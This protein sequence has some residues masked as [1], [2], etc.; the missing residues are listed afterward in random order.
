MPGLLDSMLK[1]DNAAPQEDPLAPK[2][3][4]FPAKAKRL[5]FLYMTGGV[6]H[7]D[8][9]DP[10]PTA[11]GRDGDGPD[12][13]MGCIFG[14]QK[15]PKTGIDVSNI[16][17]QIRGVM[18]HATLIRSMRSAH[19][20]HT[21]ATLGFHTCAAQFSRPSW[22]SW[23]SY[24]LGTMNRDLPSFV[25]IAPSLPYGGTRVY[26][27]DFLPAIHQGTRILPGPS[28]VADLDPHPNNPGLQAEELAFTRTLNLR[29]LTSRSADSA[30]Q[31]RIKSYETAFR[32]QT[33]AP[34]AF[35]LGSEP[36][37]ILRLYG[38][39]RGQNTGF[40]WQCLIARRLAERGVRCIEAVYG[41]A[42]LKENWDSHAD[43]NEHK[44][45]ALR[46][47]QPVAALIRD[48]KARGMLNDTIVVWATEFGRTPMK[49]QKFG[50]HHHG[51]CFS[52]WVAGGGFKAGHVHGVTDDRGFEIVEGTMEIYDLYATILH[53]MGI[54][55][56]RLTFRHAGRDFRL[57]D[58]HGRVVTE[59]LA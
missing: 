11:N 41:G 10:K 51:K 29:H 34:E 19:F 58:V 5:I 54:D 57:T 13:L 6:S 38:L 21:E 23:L 7:I 59:L 15:D 8:S 17:P 43:M 32:M 48:L 56:T 46:V 4:H 20:D 37:S 42:N 9:F 2:P 52:I 44:D 12:K 1:A 18:E 36:D 50:R 3:T 47:D 27:N 49:D 33:A 25:V 35:D 31:A 14:Y 28:P 30:L 39:E 26:A 40:N 16:F 45:H 55:H 53:Q 22:G 24:G